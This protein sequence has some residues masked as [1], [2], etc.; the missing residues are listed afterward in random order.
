[1]GDGMLRFYKIDTV[2]PLSDTAIK[3]AKPTPNNPKPKAR[4]IALKSSPVWGQKKSK[5]GKKKTRWSF[6]T[7]LAIGGL[8]VAVLRLAP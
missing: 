3:N 5:H 2:M 4:Q 6:G 1:M 7:L 8:I